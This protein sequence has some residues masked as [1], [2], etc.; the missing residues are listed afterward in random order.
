M[1]HLVIDDDSWRRHHLVL[2]DLGQ[3]LDFLKLDLDPQLIHHLLDQLNGVLA[4]SAAH[5]QHF[6]LFHL[7]LLIKKLTAIRS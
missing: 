2:H 4:V 7:I 1:Y 5:A 3:G 6:Y